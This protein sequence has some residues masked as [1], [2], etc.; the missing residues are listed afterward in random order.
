MS[1][2]IDYIKSN[3]GVT[4]EQVQSGLG[5]AWKVSSELAS[6]YKKGYLTREESRRTIT[7]LPVYAYTATAKMAKVGNPSTEKKSLS[8]GKKDDPIT[9][10]IDT[11]A[12]ALAN[13][14]V[15]RVSAH[16]QVELTRILPDRTRV[17]NLPQLSVTAEKTEQRKPRVLVV[18]LLPNQAGEISDLF[19]KALDLDFY[20]GG[21]Y[22]QHDRQY[23]SKADWA[24]VI[25]LNIS[26]VGHKHS[27]MLDSMGKDYIHVR[28]GMSAAKTAI[29]QWMVNR[30][31]MA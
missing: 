28:G 2:I 24:D 17:P 4:A 23:K 8:L 30:E 10:L 7:N 12:Q 25:F 20:S 11:L 3:P 18:G 6:L 27:S 14:F 22:E 13:Q 9:S 21:N 26:L 31:V 19:H 5:L 1:K 15:S 16:L 29:T